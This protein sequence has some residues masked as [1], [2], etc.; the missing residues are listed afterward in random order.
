MALL[1]D[2]GFRYNCLKDGCTAN[3][4]CCM[5]ANGEHTHYWGRTVEVTYPLYRVDSTDL[6]RKTDKLFN[7]EKSKG[8]EHLCI[9][10]DSMLAHCMCRKHKKSRHS[11]RKRE[12]DGYSLIEFFLDILFHGEALFYAIIG[13]FR[14][15]GRANVAVHFLNVVVGCT[16]NPADVQNVPRV[17]VQYGTL[18]LKYLTG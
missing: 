18:L 5:D 1:A 2:S 14:L 6:S 9:S 11:E 3:C 15:C 8:T 16:G 13:V 7:K 10:C 4:S 12:R 17:R